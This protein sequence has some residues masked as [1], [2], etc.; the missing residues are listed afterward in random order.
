[1]PDESFFSEL[2]RRKV[3]QAAA[4]YGAVAWGVTEVVVTV[5][6][7]LFLPRWISALT[8]ILFVVGFP[9][10]MF[11][12]WT[13]DFTADGIQRTA[14]ASRRGR[15]SIVISLLLL[16]AGTGGLFLLIQPALNREAGADPTP[17][18]PANAMAVLPFD[19]AGPAAEDIY[20]AEGLSDEVRDLLGRVEGLQIAARSSSVTAAGLAMDARAVAERLGVARI[21]EATVRRQANTLRVSVQLIDGSTGLAAWTRRFERGPNELLAL[22]QDIVQGVV[23]EVLPDAEPAPVRTA[24]R[25][26]TAGELLMIA[27]Q[28]ELRVRDRETVDTAL[29]S[30]AISLYRRAIELDPESALAHSRL[31]NALLYLGDLDAAEAP[32]FRALSL[33]P[34]L[35]EVQHTRGLY[36]FAR[37]DPE[38]VSAFRRAVELNPHNA[39]ALGSYGFAL[40]LQRYEDEVAPLFRRALELDRL[41]LSRYGAL[42]ELL[43]KSGRADEVYELIGRIEDLFDGPEACRLISR[44]YELTGD[45]DRAIGWALRARDF[46]PGNPDHQEWLAELYALLDEE[47]AALSFADSPGLGLLFLLR[48]YAEAI[49][50]GEE[51]M[52]DR[53]EDIEV[54]YLL[55]QSQNAIGAFESSLW[56]LSSSGQPGVVQNLPRMG[57]DWEGFFALVNALHGAGE[58]EMAGSLARWYVDEPRHHDNPDW[59]VE[60]HMACMLALL[61]RETEALQK[62]ELARRSPRLASRPT[63]EDAPCFSGLRAEPVYQATVDHFEQR[64]ARLRER[65]PETLAAMGVNP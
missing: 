20:L 7:Q 27:R 4:I 5:V 58:I 47:E 8:V 65:L 3:V 52:I 59:F 29:L 44:L 21:L 16:V 23:A 49:D 17:A 46:E 33:D 40:W 28:Y 54:R 55:A 37:G 15:A 26:A 2:R 34:D 31:A 41:S 18:V 11:L 38:A 56:V 43:G 14:V 30:E 36:F 48:H 24:T 62:L 13:F 6:D 1:M 45:V 61:G 60:T 39:D 53:P 35:S 57:A 9:V 19:P 64:R 22:Q 25:D 10:A 51:L 12:A 50:L 42:G 32:I 63:L